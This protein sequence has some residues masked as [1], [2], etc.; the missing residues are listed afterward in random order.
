MPFLALSERL[1]QA[2]LALPLSNAAKQRLVDAVYRTAGPA[3]RGMVHYET[4][5]RARSAVVAT[6]PAIKSL[7]LPQLESETRFEVALKPVVSIIVCAERGYLPALR[8]LHRIAT[9]RPAV[10]FEVILIDDAC[11]DRD[12]HKLASIPSLRIER[13]GVPIGY[14]RCCNGAADLAAGEYL[15]FLSD[16]ILIYDGWLD[17]PRRTRR[18]N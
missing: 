14:A 4:W 10:G 18:D 12:M 16:Q 11:A 17:P 9:H 5:K 1:R 15:H 7:P 3:F 2:Y 13:N 8:C 6:P